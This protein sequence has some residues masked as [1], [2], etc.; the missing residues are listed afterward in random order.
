MRV[1]SSP[2]TAV[3]EKR[4]FGA[5]FEPFPWSARV[6]FRLG[7]GLQ[8]AAASRFVLAMR[9]FSGIGGLGAGAFMVR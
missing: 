6:V 5:L 2:P 3:L 7:F 4:R 8:E 1:S 9:I